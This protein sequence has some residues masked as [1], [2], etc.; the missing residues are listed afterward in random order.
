[1]SVNLDSQ[2]R[3]RTPKSVPQTAMSASKGRLLAFADVR[4]YQHDAYALS[5]FQLAQSIDSLLTTADGP[6]GF[7]GHLNLGDQVA[8][9]RVPSWKVDTRLLAD[10]AAAS[11]APDEILRSQ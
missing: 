2:F 10:Q 5:G 3:L 9:R 11:I 1:M 4:F 8:G 6:R 7:F